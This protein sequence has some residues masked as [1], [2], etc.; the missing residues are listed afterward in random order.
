MHFCVS[1]I[2]AWWFIWRLCYIRNVL[3]FPTHLNV[4]QAFNF[5][6]IKHLFMVLA[7]F[8]E[9][10]FTLQVL[11]YIFN[12]NLDVN[13]NV[14]I[15]LDGRM[16]V[17]DQFCLG[18]LRSVARIFSPLLARKS[19]GFARILHDFFFCPNMAV[20]KILGGCSHPS[21]PPPPRLIR[22]CTFVGVTRA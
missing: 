12:G 10:Y 13:G 21:P 18:G 5:R 4:Y 11:L 16:G 20:W 7:R 22:L 8:C 15:I 6:K 9:I 1:S 19:S 3:L 2:S 17:R 14:H